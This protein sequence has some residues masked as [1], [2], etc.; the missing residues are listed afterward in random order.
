MNNLKDTMPNSFTDQTN[1]AIK[2]RQS[3]IDEAQ[4]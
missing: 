3:P 2:G 1:Y 4:T